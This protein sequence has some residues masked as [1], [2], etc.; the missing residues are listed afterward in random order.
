MQYV[1]I[2]SRF[3]DLTLRLTPVPHPWEADKVA[4]DMQLTGVEFDASA[5]YLEDDGAPQTLVEFCRELADEHKGFDGEKQ[6]QAVGA[7]ATL[8][9]DHDQIN[10]TR[11]HVTLTG[12]PTPPWKAH[13]ELHV[14]PFRF[15]RV[16]KNLEIYGRALLEGDVEE[17]A[18]PQRIEPRQL[19]KEPR[20]KIGTHTT[21]FVD[22]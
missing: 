22:G 3:G 16:A 18:E 20:K 2:E 11:L 14:D 5:V 12:G 4:Y 13:A 15:D 19:E 1:D 9:A 17:G 10:T 6:W 7:T 21:R 8:R